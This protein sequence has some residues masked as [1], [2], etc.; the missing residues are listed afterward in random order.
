MA[1]TIRP[2]GITYIGRKRVIS[3]LIYLQKYKNY[4]RTLECYCYCR[5]I[6]RPWFTHVTLIFE[7]L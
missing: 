5:F 1:S 4:S 2:I 6:N 7:E 3:M